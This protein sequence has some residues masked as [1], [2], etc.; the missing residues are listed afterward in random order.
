MPIYLACLG[1][2]ACSSVWQVTELVV[3]KS[4]YSAITREVSNFGVLRRSFFS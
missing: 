3:E 2:T 4:N 1:K